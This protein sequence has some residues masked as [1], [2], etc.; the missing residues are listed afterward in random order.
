MIQNIQIQLTEH[1]YIKEKAI[2]M[3][4]VYAVYINILYIKYKS[5]I[6]N[7]YIVYIQ[8][9]NTYQIFLYT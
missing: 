9:M 2:A 5:I 7:K 3:H 4:T 1:L 8:N 6:H